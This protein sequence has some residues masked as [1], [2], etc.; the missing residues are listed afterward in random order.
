MKY[1]YRFIVLAFFLVM[2]PRGAWCVVTDYQN[3]QLWND[4]NHSF[5]LEAVLLGLCVVPAAILARM[6]W[7]EKQ[8]KCASRNGVRHA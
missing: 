3:P 7:A 4:P 2:V 8:R 5:P 6:I 1:V